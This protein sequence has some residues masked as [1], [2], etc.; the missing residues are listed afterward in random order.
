MTGGSTMA[1][2]GVVMEEVASH[3]RKMPAPSQQTMQCR[4]TAGDY[5]PLTLLNLQTHDLL[6][7]GQ[8]ESCS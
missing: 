1:V 4:M 6:S 8:W 7:P 2:S 5:W 3:R